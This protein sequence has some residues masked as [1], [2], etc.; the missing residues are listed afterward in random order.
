MNN[1]NKNSNMYNDII[2]N[3]IIIFLYTDIYGLF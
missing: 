3:N 1:Y 2:V